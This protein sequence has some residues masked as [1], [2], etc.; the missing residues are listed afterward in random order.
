METVVAI[1][2]FDGFHLGHQELLKTCLS[3]SEKEGLVSA[4]YKIET[5]R[6]GIL[7]L[8]E[9]ADFLRQ[10]GIRRVIRQ[11]FTEAFSHL[12]PSAFAEQ[13][14]MGRL[15]CRAVVVGEDFRF[16]YQ[17]QGDVELL[18]K[19]GNRYGFQVFAVPRLRTPDGE[20]SST[21]IRGFLS[22]G[23]VREA[24]VLLGRPYGFSGTVAHGKHLGT[25][26]GFPTVNLIPAPEKLV[27]AFGV[28]ASETCVTSGEDEKRYRSI[29]N[30]GNNPSVSDGSRITVETFL[31][32]F[33][34]DLYGTKVFVS[35]RDYIRPEIRFDSVEKLSE[36]IKIDVAKAEKL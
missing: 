12:Q 14:L 18:K 6:P 16:G 29:T 36:Q 34:G 33:H 22:D 1:G 8:N 23:K 2:K 11:P 32:D 20:I 15:S 24:S 13:E 9:Q 4:V 31:Y 17:R 27:P 35:L 3:V 19:L 26:L 10:A 7:D 21:R 25:S 28:Y 5:E 30:V